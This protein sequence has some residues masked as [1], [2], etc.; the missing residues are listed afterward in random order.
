MKE[1]ISI[2]S[3]LNTLP[4][5]YGLKNS[6][7]SNQIEIVANIPSQCATLLK[8]GNANIGLVPIAELPTLSKDFEIVTNFCIG[9]EGTVKSVLLLSNV[10]VN[11]I[12]NIL[13]DYQSKTSINLVKILAQELWKKDFLYTN[14]TSG[15]ENKIKGNTAGVV[16]GDRALLMANNFTYCYD[17]SEEWKKLT[18]LPFVFAVWVANKNIAKGFLNDFSNALQ[19]GITNISE[20]IY[21]HT[22]KNELR[23]IAEPYLKNNISYIFDKPKQQALELF[24]QKIQCF[25]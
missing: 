12:E 3:Y 20:A 14:A 23:D 24:L 25:T 13:L 16:I 9:T 6:P 21:C 11:D 18:G 17:L 1:K 4:F 19:F 7:L 15:Y 10:P 8:E 22:F 5:I 2:V